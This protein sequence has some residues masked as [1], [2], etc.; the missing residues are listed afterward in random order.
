M[1]K[2]PWHM[3][4]NISLK[5]SESIESE[6]DA[7]LSDKQSMSLLSD[8][9]DA[10]KAGVQVAIIKGSSKMKEF[11]LL[12]LEYFKA[13]QNKD[14]DASIEAAKD[15]VKAGHGEAFGISESSFKNHFTKKLN[16]SYRDTFKAFDSAFEMAADD[17]QNSG[18]V[19]NPQ[20]YGENVGRM[21]AFSVFKNFKETDDPMWETAQEFLKGFA[22]GVL[23][24]AK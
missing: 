13:L 16:E 21:S 3:R 24:A 19:K 20:V 5:L 6:V 15:L 14:R 11:N 10:A 12:S 8:L 22:E 18:L 9:I 2:M 17:L 23:R 7:F 4:E 1:L